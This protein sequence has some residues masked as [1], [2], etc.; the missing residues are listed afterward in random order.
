MI[1]SY[2]VDDKVL[3][4][5]ET[6]A[7]LSNDYKGNSN[8][9]ALNPN[10]NNTTKKPLTS[11]EDLLKTQENTP[12]TTQEPL[13]P[14]EQARAEKLAK[15]ESESIESGN[16]IF[17]FYSDR[18]FTDFKG[19]SRL[20]EITLNASKSTDEKIINKKPLTSQEDLLKTKENTQ[21]NSQDNDTIL[22]TFIPDIPERYVRNH[23]RN[24]DIIHSF[25]QPN[26]TAKSDDAL[27]AIVVYGENT[28]KK[29]LTSQEDLL[30]TRENLFITET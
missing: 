16:K 28:T 13:S 18:N 2:E 26:R 29:P 11:Q 9:S 6:L 7:P 8:Y 10:E 5:L 1:T 14:L 3:R 22:R 15:L 20:P 4:E 19:V 23:V 21:K 25:I 27:D 30:K 12:N 17:D 24:A